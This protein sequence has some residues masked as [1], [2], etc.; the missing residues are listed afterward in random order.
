[1]DVDNFRPVH[2][3]YFSYDNLNNSFKVLLD[4]GDFEK[5]TPPN[6][7]TPETTELK[8]K[9]ETKELLSYFLIGLTLPNDKFWVNLR[10][11]SPNQIIDFNLEET[12]IGK[13][14]LEADLQLKK[15]TAQL[16]S[17]QAPEGREY[18]MR[19]YKKA[20][21][22]Y[23]TE[24]ITIPTL[25]RP[26]I[27]PNEIIV[28]ETKDSAYIY[29][30]T[31]KVML[32]QDY[33]K[34]S[35]AAITSNVDYTFKDSRSRALNEYSTQ[36]IREL[37]IP[38]L[39]KEVNL[40]K[41]YAALRQVYYSLILSRWFKSRFYGQS[42]VYASLIDKNDLTNLTSKQSWS[43][44]TYFN[45]YKRSFS[46]GEYNIQEPVHTPSG[47][48][49]RSYFSGGINAGSP[50]TEAIGNKF[51]TSMPVVNAFQ[52]ILLTAT[53]AGQELEIK[54]PETTQLAA[55]PVMKILREL[56]TRILNSEAHH[57][58]LGKV[59]YYNTAKTKNFID[60]AL[61]GLSET[62]RELALS[63]IEIAPA[64]PYNYS[65]PA[66]LCTVRVDSNDAKTKLERV[67]STAG[68]SSAVKSKPDYKQMVRWNLILERGLPEVKGNLK[69][70]EEVLKIYKDYILAA[71][72]VWVHDSH[73]E[74]PSF[75]E[76]YARLLRRQQHQMRVGCDRAQEKYSV[77]ANQ[78]LQFF[79]QWQVIEKSALGILT[80]LWDIKGRGIQN[81]MISTFALNDERLSHSARDK[82]SS[83]TL[84]SSNDNIERIFNTLSSR[85][86]D[87]LTRVQAGQQ[88]SSSSLDAIT[89]V[90][91]ANIN[92]FIL[93]EGIRRGVTHTNKIVAM[94][95]D[96]IAL[97]YPR[98]ETLEILG[99]IVSYLKGKDIAAEFD[100]RR[101]P[102]ERIEYLNN[103]ILSSQEFERYNEAD[104]FKLAAI[105]ETVIQKLLSPQ[106]LALKT[107]S[108]PLEKVTLRDMHNTTMPKLIYD[109]TMER[110]KEVNLRSPKAFR[111]LTARAKNLNMPMDD[112][113]INYLYGLEL[114]N[115][116]GVPDSD[117]ARILRIA[118]RK[119][120]NKQVLDSPLREDGI[121]VQES[122][123]SAVEINKELSEALVKR[124]FISFISGL[125]KKAIE[126]KGVVSS[127][128][129]SSRYEFENFF[130]GEGAITIHGKID[131]KLNLLS[132]DMDVI[133][134]LPLKEKDNVVF[135]LRTNILN[136]KV[137]A[138]VETDSLCQ[139]QK[140]YSSFA[141]SYVKNLSLKV[142]GPP[143][144]GVLATV[145]MIGKTKGCLERL[146][147][148]LQDGSI[149]EPALWNEIEKLLVEMR[150][151][152]TLDSSSAKASSAVQDTLSQIANDTLA[153]IAQTHPKLTTGLTMRELQ[154]IVRYHFNNH[155]APYEAKD[156]QELLD[157][158]VGKELI[159]NQTN[160]VNAITLYLNQVNLSDLITQTIGKN[161]NLPRLDKD[162]EADAGFER[163][164]ITTYVQKA[165]DGSA[166][167]SLIT[168][169]PETT[170]GIDFKHQSMASATTY[171]AL[172]SFAGLDF[173]LPKLSSSALFSFNLD[174]EQTDI[175]QAIDNGMLVSGQRI[176]EF[177]SASNAKGELEQRRDTVITWLAKLGILEETQC[178]NQ[179]SSKEYREALV[180]A[181]KNS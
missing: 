16:T 123:S 105:L 142:E 89:A 148:G 114:V 3:R 94:L 53:G 60:N 6:T 144:D 154:R 79:M 99:I 69:S 107:V 100:S 111:Q 7:S 1:M 120:G 84:V 168:N 54:N 131:E 41:K 164:V 160:Y 81:G 13:I 15:D 73:Q 106:S 170:G 58:T 130:G 2:L 80:K 113:V 26:W 17:P 88:V 108:S 117:A 19:L 23:G 14:M 50:L 103:N 90:E 4:K 155:L 175:T 163:S 67:I 138:R 95:H 124:G 91:W 157:E 75:V 180:I 174:K 11:D 179:E 128:D 42:G 150:G 27:V 102:R 152:I 97:R 49:I 109:L 5:T 93:T 40:S 146:A 141:E 31:L 20:E 66:Y 167:S 61:K 115:E 101:T 30:A 171:E 151:R 77:Y 32:E 122:A 68:A 110:L 10:P 34:S 136:G 145:R 133:F 76:H 87:V 82:I 176:K 143:T 85:M 135:F 147:N 56:G 121:A 46:E 177:M 22:I 62:D 64:D 83:L 39:T 173:S 132:A 118:V 59:N 125:A 98:K 52:K 166:A 65:N 57:S 78:S 55:S 35:S 161:Q 162:W 37:I 158:S 44:S 8:L 127:G 169:A 48:T 47:Q 119:V 43:K 137:D 33:L 25:T 172:G 140:Q 51:I 149:N 112:E 129:F 134:N 21:E 63:F 181:E 38:K 28:R 116:Y 9:E 86:S 165:I 178:C 104:K 96:T 12:D 70:S 71:I 24:N 159:Y 72:E 126:E 45:E 153:E 156:T 139:A 36:L 18:W 29:K 92:G 74:I